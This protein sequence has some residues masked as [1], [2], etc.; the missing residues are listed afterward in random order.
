[1]NL[2]KKV[3]LVT[4]ASSGIGAATAIKFADEGAIVAIN[5]LSNSAGAEEVKQKIQSKGGSGEIFQADV[6]RESEAE[7]LIK[8][9]IETFGTLDILINNAGKYHDGD[10]WDGTFDSWQK[11]IETNLYTT[12]NCSKYA[13]KYFTENKKGVI[14]NVASKMA[15]DPAPDSIV[16][17][18]AKAG[19]INATISY[20]K[21]LA[22]FG[23]VN[24]VSPGTTKAGY[25]TTAPQEEI[26]HH[27]KTK[28]LHKIAEPEDIADAIV[29]LAS[30]KSKMITA[31]NLLVDGGNYSK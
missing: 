27:L 3:V 7:D 19:V 22:P 9:V 13:T 20:A 17:S 5:F 24:S 31:Q 14:V 18:A 23:R 30:D 2:E 26:E 12:L 8:K 10:E 15:F 1:M 4:G 28:L 6:S 21:L 25:W 29:F 16:Y 11:T